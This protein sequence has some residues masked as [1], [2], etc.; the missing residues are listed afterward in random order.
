MDDLQNEVLSAHRDAAAAIAAI[1]IERSKRTGVRSRSVPNVLLDRGAPVTNPAG[2][3][4]DALEGTDSRPREVEASI[5]LA[6]A[7]LKLGN[8]DF[9]IESGLGQVGW[10]SAMALELKKDADDL[11]VGSAERARLIG[12]SLRCQGAAAKLMLSLGALVRLGPE[13]TVL[14]GDVDS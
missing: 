5:K 8:L 6:A 7:Q 1:A 11:P 12:L 14:V 4:A 10:L 13:G 3:W 2:F 9:V